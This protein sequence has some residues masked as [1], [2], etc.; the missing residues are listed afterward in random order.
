MS[1]RLRV[2]RATLAGLALV[3]LSLLGARGA[4]AQADAQ[5]TPPA[6]EQVPPPAIDQAQ[7]G[8]TPEPGEP[9]PAL[10]APS[11]SAVDA[12]LTGEA[13]GSYIYD[14]A[15]R[16]DPF[17]NPLER[18]PG[19]QERQRPPGWEGMLIREVALWGITVYGDD[20]IAIFRGSDGLGYFIREGE[21]LWDGK[22]I[23]VDFDRGEVVFQQKVDDPTSPVRFREVIQKLNP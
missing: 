12:L 13:A 19:E 7:P 3:W 18:L 5:V 22:V 11:P 16:R 2:C 4:S 23:A 17:V 15:G 10:L 20:P 1:T 21:E 14:D 9:M 8:L 6:A